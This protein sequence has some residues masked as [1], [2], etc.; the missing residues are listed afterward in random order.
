MNRL[1]SLLACWGGSMARWRV[2]RVYASS[3]CWL[4]LY[5]FD[6]Y[7][8]N[9]VSKL[10]WTHLCLWFPLFLAA[11]REAFDCKV[12]IYFLFKRIISS[13]FCKKGCF[14][15]PRRQ[16]LLKRSISEQLLFSWKGRMKKNE[17][18]KYSWNGGLKNWGID[19]C[20]AHLVGVD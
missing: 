6:N 8:F 10:L 7:L 19:G 4:M 18:L 13:F 17:E 16:F 14:L 2:S 15:S 3:I 20:L 5:C 12:T 1:V 9:E 11:E